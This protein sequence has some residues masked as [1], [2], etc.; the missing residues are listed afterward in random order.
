M[1]APQVKNHRQPFRSKKS[2]RGSSL[3]SWAINAIVRNTNSLPKEYVLKHLRE[4]GYPQVAKQVFIYIEDN[5]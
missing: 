2:N 4:M 1:T 3:F 5:K